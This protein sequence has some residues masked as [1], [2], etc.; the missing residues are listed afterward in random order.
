MI[1]VSN[2]SP[3]INLAAVGQL[4]LLKQL[5]GQVAVPQAVYDE[6]VVRGAGLPGA[7][8]VQAG[9]WIRCQAAADHNVVTAL[10]AELD[11]GEAETIALAAEM[12]ADLVL[13]DERMARRVAARFD[14]KF[15]G[16]LGVL[17]ESKTQGLIPAVKPVVDLLMSQAGF[18]IDDSLYQQILKAADE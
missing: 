18:W 1:V 5:Y 10:L 14:L 6:I 16:L 7:A 3:L 12:H 17:M 8:E 11:R 9:D 15:V 2:T 13:L 4:G